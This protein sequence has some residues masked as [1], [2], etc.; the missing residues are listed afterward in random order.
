LRRSILANILIGRARLL[1]SPPGTE[2][3]QGRQDQRKPSTGLIGQD[4]GEA[5]DWPSAP[6]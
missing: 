2:A 4:L 1:D 3:R 5:V 6:G